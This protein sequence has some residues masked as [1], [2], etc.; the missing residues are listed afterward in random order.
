M[1]GSA[2]AQTTYNWNA[3]T[4]NYTDSGNWTPAGGAT[5]ADTAKISNG[6]T[7][8]LAAGTGVGFKLILENASSMTVTGGNLTIGNSIFLGNT[9][10][11]TQN[12]TMN[13]SAG[14]VAT[15]T[16]TLGINAGSTGI[17]NMS[18]GN[19][20]IS[21]TLTVGSTANGMFTLT[22]GTV[23]AVKID[24]GSASTTSNGTLSLSGGSFTTLSGNITVGLLGN[25]TVNVSDAGTLTVGSSGTK[26]IV[27]ASTAGKTGTLNVGTGAAAGS[28]SALDVIGG[29]GTA[30]VNF[31]HTGA[32]S[33][34]PLLK[35]S[36]SVNKSGAGTTTLSGNNTYTG[37]TAINAGTMLVAGTAANSAFT[38][39]S[40]GT[41]GGS[42]TVGAVTVDAGG[43][44]AP[45]SGP[46]IL[47]AGNLSLAGTLAAT[48]NGTTVG[49]QYNQAN[50]TGTVNLVAGNNITLS[51]G[52]S[53]TIGDNIFLIN[54]DGADAIT[55]LLNGYAQ[56]ST[57][58]LTG[59]NWKISYV[60]DSGTNSFTGGNDLVIQAIIPEPATWALLAATGTFFMVMRRRCRD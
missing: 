55:G 21:S 49:A 2:S 38:V 47:N 25:G 59:Q 30:T 48:I 10:S 29:N 50:V 20:T 6:G 58:N 46:G 32:L 37:A 15:Q 19:L 28:I 24:I 43:T 36:L 60:G 27:L 57:F 51:L 52:Y 13:I 8:T 14:T 17:V 40:G 31:N 1:I 26:S 22:G 7:A 18:G 45:G 5:S 56:D 35:G 11:G 12:G 23:S 42:G 44:L 34:S 53:P 9:A 16:F 4:G 33:F 3:G 41:L 39:A 54:N